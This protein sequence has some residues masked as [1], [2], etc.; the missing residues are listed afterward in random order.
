MLH[1]SEKDFIKEIKK[2]FNV[3]NIIINKKSPLIGAFFID[4]FLN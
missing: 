1:N 3:K 4:S 2:K